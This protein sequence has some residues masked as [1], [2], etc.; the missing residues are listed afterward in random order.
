LRES[1]S[2]IKC[3]LE[4]HNLIFLFLIYCIYSL[5]IFFSLSKGH[6]WGDDFAHYILQAKSLINGS[7]KSFVHGTELTNSLS[8]VPHSPITTP[9]GFPLVL[10]PFIK[11]FALNLF[12]LKLVNFLVYS[13]FLWVL[14]IWCRFRLSKINSLFVFAFFA[15]NPTLIQFHNQILS[16]LLF[17]FC[18]TTSL[19]L[20]ELFLE[21]SDKKVLFGILLGFFIFYASFTRPGG[22][23]LLLALFFYQVSS[24]IQGIKNKQKLEFIKV[25]QQLVPCIIFLFFFLLQYFLLA[26]QPETL[27]SVIDNLTN[28]KLIRNIRYYFWLLAD[29]FTGS[30]SPVM[31]Y[32][33]T[34]S[35]MICGIIAKRKSLVSWSII[36][37][38]F[39]TFAIYICYPAVQGIRYLF[40]VLPIF[41]VYGIAG[42][43]QVLSRTGSAVKVILSSILI[44]LF[45]GITTQ[46][47][48][49]DIKNAVRNMAAERIDLAGPFSPQSSEM[50]TFIR[51]NTPDES[52]MV[53]FKPRAMRLLAERNTFF[54]NT[55]QGISQGNYVIW[56]KNL[57]Y[58]GNLFQMTINEVEACKGQIALEIAFE[59]EESVVYRISP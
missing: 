58:P 37:F 15:F 50:F 38:F 6:D 26:S 7:E 56:M 53:F 34:L 49:V 30:S 51:N 33:L 2:K 59:N 23:L 19:Y 13:A 32:L 1:I 48:L 17:L 27:K 52:I 22:Y 43:N 21:R 20:M 18:S 31:L 47:I 57:E 39:T 9:W 46:F 25:F 8:T 16:D 36:L 24:L 54:S 10:V 45:I 12:G 3:F 29:I 11:I 28:E 55:C 42:I 44:V 41:I 14:Y 4:K 5:F 35:F 40:P